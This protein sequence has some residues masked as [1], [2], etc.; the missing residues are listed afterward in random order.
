[1]H[2][3]AV[4]ARIVTSVTAI[5][6]F[7]NVDR[8]QF[9]REIRRLGQPAVLR[10]IAGSW[11][12][13]HAASRGDDALITYIKRFSH[14]RAF[15]AIVGEPDIAG[16]FFYT[17][18]VL[19]LNFTRG[20]SPLNPFLDRL[21]RDRHIEK[22]FAM[23]MQ[24]VPLADLLPNFTDEN[25]IAL[26]DRTVAPRLWLG[27]A[28]RVAAH[29]DLMENIGVVVAGR[30]RFTLFPPD[31]LP[32]LYMGPLE[33]T[34]AGTPVSMVDLDQPDF[35]QF[36][37][38]AEALRHA[39]SAELGPGDAIYIPFHWWHAVDSISAINVFV[40]YW[41]NAAPTL[42]SES[43]TALLTSLAGIASLPAD[44]RAAWR[45]MFDWIVF[46]THGDPGAHLP[47]AVRGVLGDIDRLEVDQIWATLRETFAPSR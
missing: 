7:A 3:S 38:F 47:A 6:E 27:N 12:A 25:S 46:R 45:I 11:P 4:E 2:L 16:R 19:A 44:Q 32:N 35:D 39:Q 28:I 33:L 13:V 42:Q 30:R 8:R 41:W 40:N 36:P 31:Q 23:A 20:Q 9:D 10:G 21:L 29:Y 18:D 24:S 1:M 43:Y 26:L 15:P 37:K 34:P 22:P 5:A 17:E 14:D